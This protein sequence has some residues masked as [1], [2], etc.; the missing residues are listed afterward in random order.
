MSESYDH[1]KSIET[2][3]FS[4]AENWLISFPA[5]VPS[6]LNITV[7]SSTLSGAVHIPTIFSLNVPG[8]QSSV[9]LPPTASSPNQ[10]LEEE[11]HS[12]LI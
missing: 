5:P 2:S 12:T 1:I 7:P 8:P 10:K 4:S 11:Q 3:L 9:S 6:A